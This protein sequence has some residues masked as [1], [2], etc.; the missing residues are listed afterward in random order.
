[1]DRDEVIIA[2]SQCLDR[3]RLIEGITSRLKEDNVIGL[4]HDDARKDLVKLSDLVVDTCRKSEVLMGEVAPDVAPEYKSDLDQAK[5]LLASLN[6]SW[7]AESTPSTILGL[8]AIL[9]DMRARLD[10]IGIQ[11][12][13]RA[14][15]LTCVLGPRTGTVSAG[16]WFDISGR[17]LH[18]TVREYDR[19]SIE[20]KRDFGL[21]L[22]VGVQGT[23][24][25]LAKVILTFDD[26]CDMNF[27]IYRK[28]EDEWVGAPPMRSW[29][30]SA[31]TFVEA[32]KQ[33]LFYCKLQGDVLI[34]PVRA[35]ENNLLDLH[36]LSSEVTGE[37]AL[38]FEPRSSYQ[39]DISLFVRRAILSALMASQ[40]TGYGWDDLI[41]KV[42]LPK[43]TVFEELHGLKDE[44]LI[45]LEEMDDYVFPK[46][47]G[48]KPEGEAWLA[49]NEAR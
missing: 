30:T 42:N 48:T 36:W 39:H 41:E 4:R 21:I 47:V 8:G 49:E 26:S 24:E 22:R 40:G 6:M 11:R 43:R 7:D 14:S 44:G 31:E 2:L 33:A 16:C 3:V 13:L 10:R 9:A 29:Q 18:L 27:D 32:A 28:C 1:M 15:S 17:S 46:M 38:T 23:T 37:R 12:G 5:S 34:Q 25:Q 20:F 19:R 45:D 35:E